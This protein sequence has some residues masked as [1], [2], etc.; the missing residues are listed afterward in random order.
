MNDS[1]S[2]SF[3]FYTKST[4][5]GNLILPGLVSFKK[6]QNET[7]FSIK[8]DMKLSFSV[9][10]KVRQLLPPFVIS[11]TTQSIFG[12]RQWSGMGEKLFSFLSEKSSSFSELDSDGYGNNQITETTNQFLTALSLEY[13]L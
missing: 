12:G 2:A 8:Q 13:R 11:N 7:I 9:T 10:C 4:K 1:L 5:K 3:C 6:S